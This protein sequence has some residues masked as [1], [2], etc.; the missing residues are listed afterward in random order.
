MHRNSV[1]RASRRQHGRRGIRI[2]SVGLAAALLT[3]SALAAGAGADELT[4]KRAKAQQVASQLDSLQGKADDLSEKAEIAKGSLLDA[5]QAVADAQARAEHATAEAQR[6][7]TQ[8]QG[9]SIDAYVQGNSDPSLDALFTENGNEASKVK[10]YLS[11]ATTN[12]ADLIDQ[13]QSAR[14]SAE[15]ETASLTE[16]QDELDA[17]N[18]QLQDSIAQAQSAIAEQASIKA[19]LDSEISDLVAAEQA[20]K[21]AEA[22]AAAEARAAQLAAQT[23]TTTARA[24]TAASTPAPSTTGTTGTTP[25]SR[26]DNGTGGGYTPPPATNTPPPS[27]PVPS[28]PAGAAGAVQAAMSRIGM[29]YIWAAA[30]PNAFD[31]SGLTSW[32]WAQAGRSLGHYTGSQYAQTRRISEGDLQPG[33]LVFFWAAG[34]GGDPSHVGLYIGGGSMVHAP[35]SGRNVQT[36]SIHYWY[37]ARLAFGRL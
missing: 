29:P 32:A 35:G 14:S 30:G 8:L 16:A 27:T 4:D 37:G 7:S 1:T 18:A 9:F 21:A 11:A 25:P 3:G 28:V 12:R 26:G 13:F 33:D 10:G 19:S 6:Y 22:Q 15:R 31:C 5:Q 2:A 34:A 36:A 24:A 17:L 20:R 23:P